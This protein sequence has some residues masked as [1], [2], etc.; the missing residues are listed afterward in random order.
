MLFAWISV[1]WIAFIYRAG[2]CVRRNNYF[3]YV[4][5]GKRLAQDAKAL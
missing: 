4:K 5:L 2:Q 3:S 1:I